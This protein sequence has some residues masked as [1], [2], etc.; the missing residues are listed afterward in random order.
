MNR[1]SAFYHVAAL[2]IFRPLL[3][4]GQSLPLQFV[5]AEEICQF[6]CDGMMEELFDCLGRFPSEREG[7][8]TTIYFAYT[9]SYTILS[10]IESCPSAI[11]PFA[12]ACEVFGRASPNY[13][14]AGL[15]LVGLRVVATRM[16]VHLPDEAMALLM[17]SGAAIPRGSG[18]VPLGMVIPQ[19][20]QV[21][22]SLND[23]RDSTDVE[24]E[25][26]TVLEKWIRM[27]V[28]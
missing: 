24:V 12:R 6:H 17:S 8:S 7:S 22:E 27:S 28:D 23:G 21:L 11:R 13:P 15:L 18:D 26:G 25:L 4:T 16:G 5:S 10:L 9:C 1:S 2:S 20:S 3:G 14:V 19:F